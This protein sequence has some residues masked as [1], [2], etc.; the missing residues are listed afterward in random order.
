MSADLDLKPTQDTY[1]AL[2]QA[3]DHFNWALFDGKLPNCLITLQRRA[4]TYGYF[5]HKRFRKGDGHKAD[6]IA[7]NPAHFQGHSCM[8]TLATLV[9]EQVHLWQAHYGEPGR[10]RYHNRE[11]A[12]KMKTIGLQPSDSG[13]EG[14]RETGDSMRHYVI[15]GGPF[16][17]EAKRLLSQGF[18]ITWTE[19]KRP[20]GPPSEGSAD[21]PEKKGS[22]RMKFTCPLCQLNAWAKHDASLICGTDQSPME[23]NPT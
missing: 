18:E 5:S 11:W 4:R 21:E 15:A 13:V 14:G 3:Y 23:P 17:A 19:N 10:G 22:T 16:E 12:D 8:E 7:L 1:D 2:Q 20:S 9:H 6:E